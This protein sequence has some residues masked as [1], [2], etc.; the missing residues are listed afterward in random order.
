MNIYIIN[1][2][3]DLIRRNK[4]ES[5]IK[6]YNLN[7]LGK[8]EFIE[9]ID[10]YTIEPPPQQFVG[11]RLAYGCTLSHLKCLKD[12]KE[13]NYNKFIV[14][15]DD[16]IL[17]YNF[18]TMLE[19]IPECDLL[20]LG[21]FQKKWENIDVKTPY[22]RAFKSLG[23]FAYMIS[24]IKLIDRIEQLYLENY[25]PIDEILF[26][27]QNEIISYVMY[28][29]LII[30]DLDASYAPNKNVTMKAMAPYLKWELN[31]YDI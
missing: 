16:I 27:L 13:K 4:M 17:N 22:Y 24:N 26:I 29:N 2:K 11:T 9:A 19:K 21:A 20:Y 10:T 6:K 8:I 30:A 25:R 31:E 14:F 18:W 12:A 7:K 1:L 5:L 23:G 28:P 15:E 3:K